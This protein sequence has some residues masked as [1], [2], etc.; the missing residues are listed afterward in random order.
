MSKDEILQKSD[1]EFLQICSRYEG[2]II[3]EDP[4]LRERLLQIIKRKNL[5]YLADLINKTRDYRQKMRAPNCSSEQKEA[6]DFE[7]KCLILETFAKNKNSIIERIN[8]AKQENDI[9]SLDLLTKYL[10]ILSDFTDSP[11][12]S[13]SSSS[14]YSSSSD[15]SETEETPEETPEESTDDP[16]LPVLEE[17]QNLLESLKDYIHSRIPLNQAAKMGNYIDCLGTSLENEFDKNGFGPIEDPSVRG[18]NKHNISDITPPHVLLKDEKSLLSLLRAGLVSPIILE[19][20]NI[21]LHE[22]NIDCC[23]PDNKSEETSPPDQFFIE[24][25][26]AY[27]QLLFKH[28]VLKYPKLCFSDSD[29]FFGI[30]PIHNTISSSVNFSRLQSRNFLTNVQLSYISHGNRFNLWIINFLLGDIENMHSSIPFL[31]SDKSL[32]PETYQKFLGFKSFAAFQADLSRTYLPKLLEQSK[33][34]ENLD[35]SSGEKKSI[36]EVLGLMYLHL[37]N[38]EEGKKYFLQVAHASSY[39]YYL[40]SLP[41]EKALEI[42]N[43]LDPNRDRGDKW[44][45]T[46]NQIE[47]KRDWQEQQ[48]RNQQG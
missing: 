41:P 48:R 19:A 4:A 30:N 18:V 25:Y 3:Q 17:A 24:K 8:K 7:Y 38:W 21:G 28:L 40:N 26:E 11:S 27:V 10:L 5:P 9:T 37:G 36:Q 43:I 45:E 20:L 23:W 33:N 42:L 31:P 46:R 34:Q 44:T 47:M 35:L 29:D 16:Y 14:S 6:I 13:S 32:H 39:H 12:F 2:D 15:S 1:E 22:W